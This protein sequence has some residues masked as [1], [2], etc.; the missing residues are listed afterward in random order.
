MGSTHNVVLYFAPECHL[1]AAAR[2]VIGQVREDT[3]FTL[4]EIDISGDPELE[5]SYRERIPVVVV[6]GEPAFTFYVHPD[7]LRR[8]LGA[9]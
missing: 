5:N 3:P 6:D 9:L 1:C 4:E 2:R 8:R 7:G